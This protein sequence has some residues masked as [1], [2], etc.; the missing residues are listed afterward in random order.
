ML[1]AEVRRIVGRRGSYWSALLIGFGAV[2]L[3]IIIRLTGTRMPAASCSTRWARSRSW[4]RSWRSSW[5]RSPGSYDTAQGTMRYLVMTGVPRRRLYATRALGTA[6]ATLICCAP[7][8]VA[9]H[10]RGLPLP[11]QRFSDPTLTSDLGAVWAYVALRSS[12][13][14]SASASARCCARTAQPSA[15][16]LGFA[17]GGS[18]ITA[19]V[20]ELHQRD[21]ASYLLPYATPIVASS[22]ATPS[23]PLARRSSPSPSW[24]AAFLARR[25]RAH[26]AR[27]V[28]RAPRGRA[29]CARPP[30]RATVAG[31]APCRRRGPSGARSV[32]GSIVM[33]GRILSSQRGMYHDF[34]PS[35]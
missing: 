4:R 19:L 8:V 18:V 34:S 11:L 20:G 33:F 3:M 25:A 23:I 5:E 10:R 29:P 15:S 22:T 12:T 17:L 31:A 30:A 9:R 2:V 1:A 13:A 35:T 28:L 26:A 21:V 24:L 32:G 7:A 27:R 16:S 6:V 14:S